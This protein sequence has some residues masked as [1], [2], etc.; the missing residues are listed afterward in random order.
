MG[1]A[2]RG[3]GGTGGGKHLNL[4]TYEITE[5]PVDSRPHAHLV[6]EHGG[7]WVGPR[8]PLPW[9]DRFWWGGIHPP[10]THGRNTGKHLYRPS[11]FTEE[12]LLASN[13]YFSTL[14]IGLNDQT[15]ISGKK[16]PQQ[17]PSKTQTNDPPMHSLGDEYSLYWA[18]FFFFIFSMVK[19]P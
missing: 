17:N 3:R 10:G 15:H 11:L 18:F 2:G 4:E 8:C 14:L 12:T 16:K 1:N 13:K 6:P 5:A 19:A 9:S 7:G